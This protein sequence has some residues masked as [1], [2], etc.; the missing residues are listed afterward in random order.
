MPTPPPPFLAIEGN[1]GAGKTT[2]ARALAE[3][4]DRRLILEE[5]SDNPFLPPFYREPERYALP[6]EL[7]FM[8]ERHKQFA[9]ELAQSELFAGG[10]VSDYF[11]EKTLLFAR[12]SLKSDEYRL[13]NRLFRIMDAGFPKPDL[14]VYLHRPVAALQQNIH[15][16]GRAFETEIADAYLE[17]VER[18]YFD[19][20]RTGCTSPVLVLELG[21]LDFVARPELVAAMATE[22]SPGLP[23]GMHY[24]KL[25]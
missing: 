17:S 20:F 21:N 12:N 10:V 1:I 23:K 3:R 7:F 14:I 25:S 24:R 11:F 5:F 16:R 13:F 15:K 18:A 4:F 2:L 9:A 8:A 19:Y 22:L 6:V